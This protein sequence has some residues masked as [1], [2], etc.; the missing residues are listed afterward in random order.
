MRVIDIHTHGMRGVDT[1][2]GDPSRILS[3]AEF[4]AR[5]GV[6]E[7]LPTIY[8]GPVETMRSQ[9]AAVAKAMHYQAIP[10][11]YIGK[12][13]INSHHPPQ[14]K[15]IGISLEGPFLNPL[16]CGS[17]DS[18][19][20]LKPDEKNLRNL[21]DGYE[22]IVKVITIAPELPGAMK[23]IR[24]VTDMGI[25]ASMGHSDATYNEALAGFQ[26][27]ARGITHL[28]NAMKGFH[29]RE[30]GLAGFGLLNQEIYVEIIA[31]SHHLSGETI[32][33]LFSVKNPERIILVSDSVKESGTLPGN[34]PV[35]NERGNLAGGALSV[36]ESSGRLIDKGYN[37]GIILRCASENPSAYLRL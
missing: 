26:A 3:F 23:I 31:D 17:L 14:A 9:M 6:T 10:D 30:A 7:F 32:R 12:D 21:I 4:Q 5:Q 20:F 13:R 15:I 18:S 34:P 1:Q 37:E 19:S 29:H 11:D 36:S 16:K 22:E 25:A 24:M 8:P 33:L 2:T 35:T 27:G 28:F